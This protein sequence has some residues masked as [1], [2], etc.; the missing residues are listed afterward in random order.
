MH[1]RL[2]SRRAFLAR[3]ELS[4]QQ[5]PLLFAQCARWEP[6]LRLQEVQRVFLAILVNTLWGLEA[7]PARSVPED[8]C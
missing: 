4:Q 8:K 6:L 1:R 7:C 2:D 5:T 3:P